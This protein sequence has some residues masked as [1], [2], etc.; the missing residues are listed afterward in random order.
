MATPEENLRAKLPGAD[1]GITRRNSVC[2]I[3]AP[4]PHCGITC[5]VKDGKLIKVEGTREHPTNH[6]LLCPKG[7]A[8][9]Q[10]VYRKDRVLTPLRRMG[11]RGEGKF[12]PIS[13][14]EA[15]QEIVPR[16]QAV[17]AQYGPCLLYTS[18]C[19]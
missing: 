9:R 6:G 14:E 5:Y 15:W 8:T 12:E 13:W 4:G 18:R 11:A 19:V 16:L 7:L 2:D 1:T 17:K 3:C 10:Y